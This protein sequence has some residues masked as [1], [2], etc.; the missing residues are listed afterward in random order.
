M[1]KVCAASCIVNLILSLT[2]FH[3]L[4][5]DPAFVNDVPPPEEVLAGSSPSPLPRD[6]LPP[7][8]WGFEDA[9]PLLQPLPA[10]LPLLDWGFHEGVTQPLPALDLGFQHSPPVDSAPLLPELV[11]GFEDLDMPVA[12]GRDV[13]MESLPPLNLGFKESVDEDDAAM[14]EALPP[15]NQ[16]QHGDQLPP[17]DLGFREQIL[18]VVHNAYR[19]MR[20]AIN[21]LDELDVEENPARDEVRSQ[22]QRCKQNQ[23]LYHQMI[24]YRRSTRAL[25]CMLYQVRA[26]GPEHRE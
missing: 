22:I 7:L 17:L 2:L 14:D 12:A 15:V 26:S 20:I 4:D 11:W 6:S 3:L 23:A 10:S 24:L 13:Q 1:W 8:T 16:E 9:S 25:S 21:K 5:H 19:M 18:P